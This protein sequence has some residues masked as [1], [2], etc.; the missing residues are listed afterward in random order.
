MEKDLEQWPD[1]NLLIGNI[2]L[3]ATPEG[4][5]YYFLSTKNGRIRSK[6]YKSLGNAVSSIPINFMFIGQRE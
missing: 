4:D 3:M 1:G 6:P 2:T 5:F